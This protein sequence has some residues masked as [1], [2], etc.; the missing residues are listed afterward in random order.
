[1]TLFRRFKAAFTT[2]A[3]AFA[4]GGV[5]LL[6]LCLL[7]SGIG[8][9]FRTPAAPLVRPV[10]RAA[11]MPVATTDL[12]K[13]VVFDPEAGLSA[14]ELM[15]RWEPTIGLAAKRFDIPAEWIRNVMRAESGGHTMLNGQ[16]IIS[17]KG[18]MGLMQ[19]LPQTY[20]EMAAENRLGA[21][22][23]DPHDNISAGAAYLRWLHGKYGYPAMFAAYN[24][25]PGYLENHLQKGVA[26]PQETRLYVA[27]ITKAL[28]KGTEWL[29]AVNRSAAQLTLTA[30]DGR[31]IALDASKISGVRAALPGEYGPGVVTVINMGRLSQGVQESASSVTA[32][33]AAKGI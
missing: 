23:F 18:A 2:R 33:L 8:A 21:D 14:S 5:L 7:L 28:G 16:P 15:R 31:K 32:L 6:S 26:L 29:T 27:G 9:L 22:P 20:A 25:G 24:A 30:P 3:P 11:P 17:E 10:L 1:M 4:L 19:V 13:P 12:S